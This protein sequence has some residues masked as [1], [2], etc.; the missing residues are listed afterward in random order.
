MRAWERTRL[1]DACGNC[2]KSLP[3]GTPVHV[4]TIIGVTRRRIRCQECAG[5]EVDLAALEAFDLAERERQP[6]R[7]AGTPIAFEFRRDLVRQVF[8]R[9]LAQTGEREC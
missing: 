1:V 5:A 4:L 7:Q 3:V 6:T 2:G 9:K 8:D